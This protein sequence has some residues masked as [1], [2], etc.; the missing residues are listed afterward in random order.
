MPNLGVAVLSGRD[1]SLVIEPNQTGDLG[2]G[3]GVLDNGVLGRAL[4]VPD[5]D[6]CIEGTAGH[7]L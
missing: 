5:D 1:Q 3:V 2:L 4:D 6:G 7:V